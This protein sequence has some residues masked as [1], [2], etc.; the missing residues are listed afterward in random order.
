MGDSTS[1]PDGAYRLQWG[2]RIPL[3]D[4]VE[5]NATLYRPPRLDDPLPAVVTM[6]PYISDTYHERG[7]YF[8]QNG[9]VFLTVDVR[10]RGNSAGVFEPFLHMSEDGYDVVEWIAA[11]P[12]C[13]GKVG[14]W[15]GSYAGQNQWA[16]LKARPPH[17]ATIAPAAAVH[18]G[19][20]FPGV[21]NIFYA[22]N[23]QWLTF[24]SGRTPNTHLFQDDAF[25]DD[26]FKQL[27]I[28]HRPFQELDALVGNLS[29]T[30][31]QWLAHPEAPAY[32]NQFLP[33]AADYA[34]FDIPI[35]TITGHF[36][37]D[38][39]GAMHYYRQH[40]QHG[41]AAAIAS[42]Y[43]IIGPYDHAGTRTPSATVGGLTF[44]AAALLDLNAL[45]KAWYDWTMKGGERPAFLQQRVAYYVVGQE[46][47]RYADSLE[48]IGATPRRYYLFAGADARRD[49]FHSGHLLETLQD[50][51]PASYIYDPLDTRSA[52]RDSR[53]EPD[54]LLS[55]RLALA[56]QGDGLIFHSTPLPQAVTMVGWLRLSAWLSLDTPDTDFYAAVYE[57]TVEGQSVKLGDALLRARYR[58]SLVKAE[59]VTPG[60]IERYDFDT[61]WF[62]ARE[63]G[64]GSYLRLVLTAP[65]T[66]H[67]MKNY[68]SG[69]V[70]AEETDADAR[71]AHVTLYADAQHPSYLELP[72]LPAAPPT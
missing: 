36:D 30:F 25:W 54:Y 34:G 68:N 28:Q 20:D 38:Q 40:M 62:H 4:G 53:P 2:V 66:L 65:N 51:P 69:G 44:D 26:K 33:S 14:M 8:A 21:H 16:T 58:H 63:L 6:T 5:L 27:F 15:G 24:T 18:L 29:P 31:Q 42:H 23:M 19:V 12:W 70:V 9:Y 37:G 45:H 72:I 22:Y 41:A 59:L 60:A 64:Q 43:L 17:L 46:K 71:T 32:W 10:G 3:R 47:W 48:A 57:I 7:R 11:Q 35:L 56:L 1:A 67:L 55:Q 52:G 39:P 49:V 13:N 61:F 50:S